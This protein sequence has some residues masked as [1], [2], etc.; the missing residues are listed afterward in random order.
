[1]AV[2]KL[3]T[4][5]Y[6]TTINGSDKVVFVDFS[7]VWCG[8]CKM[9]API[10]DQFASEHTSEALCVSVDID[11][12]RELAM[13]YGIQAVPTTLVIKNGD[14]VDSMMGFSDLATLESKLSRALG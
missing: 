6:D 11:E 8:P 5:N 3:T 10:F 4:A 7:A 2:E 9:F 13:R 1:M 12:S 14:V